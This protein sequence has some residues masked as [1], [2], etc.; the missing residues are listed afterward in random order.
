VTT[1][2][3]KDLFEGL[4][5]E[6]VPMIRPPGAAVARRTVRRR[7]TTTAMLSAAAAVLAVTGGIAVLDRRPTTPTVV[8]ASPLPSVTTIAPVA[9]DPK[10][11]AKIA[12]RALTGENP[13]IDVAV[14]VEAG[15][16]KE[17][18]DFIG[19]LTLQAACAGPGRFEL[20]VDG[21]ENRTTEWRLIR[22]MWVQC[23]ADPVPVSTE[24]AMTSP[25]SYYRFRLANVATNLENNRKSG[26][27]YRITS[28]TG[29]PIS[30]QDTPNKIFNVDRRL[31]LA[32]RNVM[33]AAS[34]R[35]RRAEPGFH[36]APQLPTGRYILVVKCSGTGT[37]LLVVRQAGKVVTNFEAPCAWPGGTQVETPLGRLDKTATVS[38]GYRSSTPADALITYALVKE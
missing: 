2:Q 14:P 38:K 32:G 5:E 19:D 16:R 26:F 36:S 28:N 4:R 27:A 29:V 30:G 1:D 9:T 12:Q 21:Q 22:K 33:S 11:L 13:A 23:S 37:A 7:R 25:Y 6:T 20:T 24:F 17:H 31:D 10:A 34:S 18:G 8:S 15:Y 3:L 35:S